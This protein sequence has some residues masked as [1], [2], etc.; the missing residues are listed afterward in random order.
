MDGNG[1]GGITQNK[2]REMYCNNSDCDSNLVSLQDILS[3]Y[4]VG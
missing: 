3:L 2:N 1:R 4:F